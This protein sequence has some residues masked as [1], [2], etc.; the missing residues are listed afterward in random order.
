ML[1]CVVVIRL[2]LDFIP[3]A[4]SLADAAEYSLRDVSTKNT[5]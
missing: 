5:L 4:A 3:S 2:V 1:H